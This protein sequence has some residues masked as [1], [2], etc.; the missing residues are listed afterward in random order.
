MVKLDRMLPKFRLI[1]GEA[2]IFSRWFLW[3]RGQN[4]WGALNLVHCLC[5]PLLL[6][7]LPYKWTQQTLARCRFRHFNNIRVGICALIISK[8][9]S[10][11]WSGY[12]LVKMWSFP[13]ICDSFIDTKAFFGGVGRIVS[14]L[15][16]WMQ[17]QNYFVLQANWTL[18]ASCEIAEMNICKLLTSTSVII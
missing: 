15:F 13:W 14:N 16:Y 7:Y 9:L 17:K 2:L 11:C 10:E 5:L 18:F 4:K 8:I 12:S 3:Q 1:I 6:L